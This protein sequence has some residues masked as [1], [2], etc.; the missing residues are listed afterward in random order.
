MTAN[1]EYANR[2]AQLFGIENRN[3]LHDHE[4]I[5]NTLDELNNLV[6]NRN[7]NHNPESLDY[8]V[9]DQDRYLNTNI[10]NN[11]SSNTIDHFM[12]NRNRYFQNSINNQDNINRTRGLISADDEVFDMINN[13][14]DHRNNYFQNSI[15][16]QAIIDRVRG[17]I[18]DQIQHNNLESELSIS[19]E[20]YLNEDAP[21]NPELVFKT[22]QKLTL[23]TNKNPIDCSICLD[24]VESNVE[25]YKLKC[26][27]VFHKSCIE[28]WLKE[29]L[30]C[31]VCRKDI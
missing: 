4:F 24:K 18:E 22:I 17:E 11:D 29:K 3:Q 10:L 19:L 16:N 7:I 8:P 14:R 12:N 1:E 9:Y 13:H 25:I 15:N 5:F 30:S 27:H 2:F 21:T 28:T 26:K 31:P 20:E 6:N 23:C